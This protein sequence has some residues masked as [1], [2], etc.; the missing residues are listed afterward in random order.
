MSSANDP[1]DPTYSG[2]DRAGWLVSI[3][4][5]LARRGWSASAIAAVLGFENQAKCKPPLSADELHRLAEDAVG[6]AKYEG[7]E[8]AVAF[9]QFAQQR[10]LEL[11]DDEEIQRLPSPT[12]QVD[13]IIPAGS[14]ALM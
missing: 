5:Q 1:H 14:L 2:R 13:G 6:Y 4:G 8:R 3:A 12:W 11:L 7:G 10:K 9:Q